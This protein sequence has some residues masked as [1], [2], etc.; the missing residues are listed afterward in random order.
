MAQS[1]TR[2]KTRISEKIKEPSLFRVIYLNDSQTTM[3]FVVE[4]LV[5]IFNHSPELDRTF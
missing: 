4:T 5:T 3:E 2:T 1:E